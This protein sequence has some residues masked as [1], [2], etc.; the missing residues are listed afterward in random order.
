MRRVVLFLVF[1]TIFFSFINILGSIGLYHYFLPVTTHA[2]SSGSISLTIEST[3]SDSEDS[4]SGG[5]SGG[6]GGGG[7]GSGASFSVALPASWV[8]TIPVDEKIL[9]KGYEADFGIDERISFNFGGEKHHVG[10]VGLDS[11]KATI[12]IFSTP[13]QAYIYPRETKKF[14]IDNDNYYDLEIKLLS[15]EGNRANLIINL[16]HEL[17]PGIPDFE[18]DQLVVKVVSRVG[19][20][21]KQF[22]TV[23]NP[24]VFPLVFNISSNLQKS[25]FLSDSSFLL[26]GNSERKIPLVFIAGED[27]TPDVYS[28]KI[29]IKTA[30][31]EREIPVIYEVY[32]KRVLFEV[33]L[34]IPLKF[35][36]LN[37]GDSLN[38][39][40]NL[41]NLAKLGSVDVDLRYEIKDLSNNIV[42]E[43]EE[44]MPVDSQVN[45]VRNI[46]LP[47]DL[48]NGDYIASV[49]AGYN[50]S[51]ST[52]SDLFSVGKERISSV[53]LVFL[54]IIGLAVFLSLVGFYE[55]RHR[56]LKNVL[57]DQNVQLN[58]LRDKLSSG[59]LKAIEAVAEV[60]KLQLQKELL[61]SAYDKG[62]VKAEVYRTSM[63]KLVA[64]QKK[65][66]EKYL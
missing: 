18:I 44:I 59:K 55:F 43:L 3:S 16:I 45:F 29:L 10:L 54:V 61:Q 47:S 14:D 63:N 9:E 41:I 2:T 42:S 1:L 7:G 32:S 25:L 66:K 46:T 23:K 4:G 39:Q 24:N 17:K 48:L 52:S 38:F 65:L 51:I 26:D 21:Y 8:E 12:V 58:N 28:G 30:Y 27:I 15:I 60:K 11:A 19:E 37:A 64:L 35:K 36:D 34:N 5:S 49:K 33:K 20:T 6:S 13:Q 31:S 50:G 53:W 62:F 56:R 40:I 57:K 22:L